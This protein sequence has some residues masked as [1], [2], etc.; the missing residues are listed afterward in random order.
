MKLI[1]DNIQ[2]RFKEQ[3]VLKGATAEFENGQIYGLLGRN[4]A[5]KTT[6]FSII[7]KELK[8]EEGTV[9]LEENGEIKELDPKETGMVFAETNLPDFLTGYE[10][11][12]FIIDI[13]DPY[14]IRN[15]DLYFEQMDLDKDDRH[16]LI[17]NYSSG[18]KAK[19]SLLTIYIQKPKVILLDEP[20]TAVDVVSGAEIKRFFRQLKDNHIVIISTHM[21]DLAKDMCDEIVLL[22]NGKLNQL[23]NLEKNENYEEIIIEALRSEND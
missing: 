11:I 22:H 8:A 14:D 16:K 13:T 6:L 10:Y 2:K 21:L 5:G 17:K 15:I 20:L 7:Y 9:K 3:E 4:G 23:K 1:L 18:M 19:L 12:K